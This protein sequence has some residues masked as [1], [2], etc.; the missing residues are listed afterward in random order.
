MSG[1]KKPA[2]PTRSS[3]QVL[4][5]APRLKIEVTWTEGARVAL[6]SLSQDGAAASERQAWSAA[7]R[8]GTRECA[9]A[10]RPTGATVAWAQ[11]HEGEAWQVDATFVCDEEMRALNARFRDRDRPTDVLSFSQAET[12]ATA[13][14]SDSAEGEA[15]ESDNESG[16]DG[17]FWMGMGGAAVL[18]DL[19]I[20]VETAHRQAAERAH[21][22]A[23][24]VLF[25]SI[26][27]TL[28][29]LGYDHGTS[30]QRRAMWREQ[31]AL[32]ERLR[33]RPRQ[34]RNGD[35]SRSVAEAEMAG[36]STSAAAASPKI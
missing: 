34:A 8:R 3:A 24:E 21:D 16:V 27:G 32:F 30:A 5:P 35:A 19:V 26:H 20:A 18:G 10:A 6:E 23:T 28:H 13:D 9:K 7:L 11:Q 17:T 25:L 2:K 33:S 36:T 22:G 1:A 15:G 12:A 29:L 31:D 4:A 14:E